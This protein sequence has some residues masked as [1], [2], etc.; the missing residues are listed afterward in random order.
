MDKPFLWYASTIVIDKIF[1]DKSIYDTEY[2]IIV[3]DTFAKDNKFVFTVVINGH[4]FTYL[5]EFSSNVC[6]EGTLEIRDHV[7]D[8]VYK[9]SVDHRHDTIRIYENFMNYRDLFLY[10]NRAIVDIN[11]VHNRKESVSCINIDEESANRYKANVTQVD[12]SSNKYTPGDKYIDML[13]FAISGAIDQQ[14]QSCLDVVCFKCSNLQM[15]IFLEGEKQVIC[16][17][18]FI[19]HGSISGVIKPVN[20]DFQQKFEYTV[21]D[22]KASFWVDE[23][24]KYK[25][26]DTT[27]RHFQIQ[28]GTKE[29]IINGTDYYGMDVSDNSVSFFKKK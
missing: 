8:K 13:L 16:I 6:I 15:V 20:S 14:V 25:N 21:S 7:D 1:V 19:K 18:Q 3:E 26:R 27:R 4:T 23:I 2:S 12:T 22:D 17:N 11:V 9:Y 28:S 5:Y 24:I 29:I 10:N